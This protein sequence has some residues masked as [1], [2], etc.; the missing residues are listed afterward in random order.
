MGKESKSKVTETSGSPSPSES[1]LSSPLS[2]GA[3]ST[4][5]NEKSKSPPLEIA[6]PETVWKGSGQRPGYSVHGV[7]IGRPT[8][9]PTP[10]PVRPI[11]VE[12]QLA[13]ITASVSAVL[14]KRGVAP[15]TPE[16][17]K[18]FRQSAAAIAAKYM[19]FWILPE[20]MFAL[21]TT[22]IALARVTG[23]RA[24]LAVLGGGSLLLCGLIVAHFKAGK[25]GKI[26]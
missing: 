10:P 20:I 6:R 15:L 16:E 11:E 24:T 18:G 5:E 12:Q 13:P 1:S 25:T 7:K 4:G 17:D 23:T 8:K 3:S 14:E 9:G 26:P 21:S 22:S 2:S 19:S